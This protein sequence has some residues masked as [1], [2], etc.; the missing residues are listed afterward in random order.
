MN[1]GTHYLRRSI[2]RRLMYRMLLVAASLLALA[3]SS[4]LAGAVIVRTH[5]PHWSFSLCREAA[6]YAL[7]FSFAVTIAALA[8]GFLGS[9]WAR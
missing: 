2:F 6:K 8:A 5:G 9:R 4:R 3:V 7:A 1:N